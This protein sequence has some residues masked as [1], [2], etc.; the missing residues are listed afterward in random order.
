MNW[1]L[2]VLKQ[3][4]KYLI[5]TREERRH[6]LVG[7]ANLWKMK[8]DFQ[9]Q[10]LKAMRLKPEH[11]LLDIGCGTLRGGI[12]FI[13]YLQAGHYFGID[14]RE[15]ALDE[16]RKELQETNLE[17]KKPTLLLSLDIS[18]LIIDQKFDYIWAFSVLI[19]MSDNI[20][21]DTLDFVSKHLSKEGIF[22]ANVIVDEMEKCDWEEFP[23]VSRT[24]DSYTQECAK[25]SLSVSDLGP[26][27]D[28][29][30]VTKV[31]SHDNQRMLK[32]TKE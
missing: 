22:Y 1:I 11:Y 25:Y 24:I 4:I 27:I 21:S 9:F 29:G 12:P 3:K 31:A 18:Q 13:T 2:E 17:G 15:K 7:P 10:F 5:Q 32:I 30:H 8:R 23:V 6:A 14:V 28:H 26:L 16:G 19:H 20:L